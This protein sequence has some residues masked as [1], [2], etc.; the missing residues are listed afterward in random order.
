MFSARPAGE[1][2]NYECGSPDLQGRLRKEGR[3]EA[4]IFTTLKQ[5]IH[6]LEEDMKDYEWCQNPTATVGA[7][8][9][10]IKTTTQVVDELVALDMAEAANASTSPAP[11]GQIRP[12]SAIFSAT[13]ST[14]PVSDDQILAK[15]RKWNWDLPFPESPSS[16][17]WTGRTPRESPLSSINSSLHGRPAFDPQE[18]NPTFLTDHRR[19]SSGS[20]NM[21]PALPPPPVELGKVL[22]FDCDICGRSIKVARRLEWQ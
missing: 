13:Q 15:G 7:A 22:S 11:S 3:Q 16:D 4:E 21:S 14:Q 12:M 1:P 5:Q 6:E 2:R 18:Q 17:F 8:H 10:I 9:S 19:G 20:L